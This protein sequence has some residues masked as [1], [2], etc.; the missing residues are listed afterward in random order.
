MSK[1]I[2]LF[3]VLVAFAISACAPLP[4]NETAI[5][6]PRKFLQDVKNIVD[7]NNLADVDAAG[8]SLRVDFSVTEDANYM[9]SGASTV[10]GRRLLRRAERQAREFEKNS[11]VYYGMFFGGA[12]G[13]VRIQIRF[14]LNPDVMC[15]T[16]VDLLD[17]FNGKDRYLV[18]FDGE[19]V[20]R[21]DSAAIV[22]AYFRFGSDGCLIEVGLSQGLIGR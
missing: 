17:V 10:S 13:P 21:G 12:G 16:N 22:Q 2:I 3:E 9:A 14:K 8:R 11:A 5:R 6:E 20:Y 4:V 19:Y 15:V 1:F 7:S 18:D